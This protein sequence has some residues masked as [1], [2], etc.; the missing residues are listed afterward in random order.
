MAVVEKK[1]EIMENKTMEQEVMYRVFPDMSRT[2]KREEKII[3]IEVSLPG[4]K[5][6]DIK[7]K[8]LP[9]WFYLTA[10]RGQMEY[11][12][13]QSFGAEIVPEKTTAKYEHGLLVIKA[14]IK[15][16]FDDAQE[17]KL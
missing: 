16:P 12:A 6:E 5:K 9:T 14:V 13:N 11:S 15:D 10:R 8:A 3:E 7:L 2:I 17:V 1:P 4:V